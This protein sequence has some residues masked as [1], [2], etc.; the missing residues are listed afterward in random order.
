MMPGAH[1]VLPLFRGRY[2]SSKATGV[3]RP[4]SRSHVSFI[5][6]IAPS[7]FF[8]SRSLE[9]PSLKISWGKGQ[10]PCS[11]NALRREE[12]AFPTNSLWAVNDLLQQLLFIAI[13]HLF[14][15]LFIIYSWMSF[16]QDLFFLI[17]YF[18]FQPAQFPKPFCIQMSSS[19]PSISYLVF[20]EILKDKAKV[21]FLQ[22]F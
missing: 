5:W 6:F 2:L 18:S 11:G 10:T 15:W 17:F 16:T 3:T 20:T 9:G 4:P 13:N 19:F 1:C 22:G 8:L 7:A 12:A 14:Y 21:P